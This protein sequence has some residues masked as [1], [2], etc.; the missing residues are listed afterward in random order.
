[1][2]DDQNERGAVSWEAGNWA[3]QELE[4]LT[5]VTARCEKTSSSGKSQANHWYMKADYSPEEIA[6]FA[7]KRAQLKLPADP[8][9]KPN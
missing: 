2:T 9:E 6:G 1:M 4:R 8:E 3:R 5:S 7:R